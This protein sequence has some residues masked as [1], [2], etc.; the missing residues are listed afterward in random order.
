M[1]A[2]TIVSL[3][4]DQL[5]DHQDTDEIQSSYNHHNLLTF[6]LRRDHS[7]VCDSMVIKCQSTEEKIESIMSTLGIHHNTDHKDTGDAQQNMEELL[8]KVIKSI[9]EILQKGQGKKGTRCTRSKRDKLKWSKS[10][11]AESTINS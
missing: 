6:K 1:W 3:E 10:L 11:N 7:S 5:T 4:T 9:E 8:P 2:H